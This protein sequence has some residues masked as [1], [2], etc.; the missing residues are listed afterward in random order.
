MTRCNPR[1]SSTRTWT[2]SSWRG[3]QSWWRN[4]GWTRA[5]RGAPRPTS[6][7]DER[8][9]P[10]AR[11]DL[12]TTAKITAFRAALG[13]VTRA[14]REC[15]ARARHARVARTARTLSSEKP[16]SPGF[17]ISDATCLLQA[18]KRVP[19]VWT[20]F[21]HQNR[22]DPRA[23]RALLVSPLTLVLALSA[24]SLSL[25]LHSRATCRVIVEVDAQVGGDFLAMSFR[26]PHRNRTPSNARPTRSSASAIPAPPYR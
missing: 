5:H 16:T 21:W 22:R 18:S 14:I 1:E 12:A 20:L 3:E 8:A 7:R 2:S 9:S 11:R 25:P 10:R 6:V 13:R 19:W 17:K 23:T 24:L 4:G 15:R 26:C